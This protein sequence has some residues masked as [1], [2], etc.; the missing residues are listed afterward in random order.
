MQL[1]NWEVE[2]DA[3]IGYGVT[4]TN[5]QGGWVINDEDKFYK[6]LEEAI[7]QVMYDFR[8]HTKICCGLEEHNLNSDSIYG[9]SGKLVSIYSRGKL[10]CNAQASTECSDTLTF[11]TE[12]KGTLSESLCRL[13]DNFFDD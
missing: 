7:Q 8:T 10:V 1:R 6:N 5:T 12:S 13:L 4:L 11:S 3:L 2:G 9:L